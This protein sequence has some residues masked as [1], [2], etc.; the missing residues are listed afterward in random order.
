MINRMTD[1]DPVA[2]ADPGAIPPESP[3]AMQDPI[4]TATWIIRKHPEVVLVTG[5]VFGLALGWWVKRK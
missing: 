2:E 5:M 1:Y 3:T 4:G